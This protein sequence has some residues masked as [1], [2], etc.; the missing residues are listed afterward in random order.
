MVD[1]VAEGAM[2]TV[3]V[4]EKMFGCVRR[5]RKNRNSFSKKNKMG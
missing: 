5:E 1:E 2:M 4:L 3:Y